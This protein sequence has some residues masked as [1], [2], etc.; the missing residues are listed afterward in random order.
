MK[1]RCSTDEIWSTYE[2]HMKYRWSTY[3]VQMKYDVQMRYRWSTDEVKMKYRWST[4]KVQVKYRW[5]TDEVQMKYRYVC[6]FSLSQS[7]PCWQ[8]KKFTN[9]M[10]QNKKSK[11]VWK[12]TLCL[13][14]YWQRLT[15]LNSVGVVWRM[16][17]ESIG[18]EITNMHL[19]THSTNDVPRIKPQ[20]G[21]TNN[22]L[23]SALVMT[24]K[25]NC[26]ENSW[27]LDRNQ[28]VLILN[29][30]YSAANNS[31]FNINQ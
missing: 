26:I 30:L 14:N 22:V 5:W 3:E 8:S 23:N 13:V 16:M 21:P 18:L 7:P 15:V 25:P 24:L 31:L 28:M 2:V 11:S 12:C 10:Y 9:I 20:S 1:Y 17:Q 27:L 19:I 29:G 6:S 4:Y